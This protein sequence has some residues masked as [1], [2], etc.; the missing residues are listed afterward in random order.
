M[1]CAN[2]HLSQ[3]IKLERGCVYS[4]FFLFYRKGRQT[5][6][7]GRWHSA[8]IPGW[9]QTSC[10]YICIFNTWLPGCWDNL[11]LMWPSV[12]HI[13]QSIFLLKQGYKGPTCDI[14]I[15]QMVSCLGFPKIKQDAHPQHPFKPPVQAIFLTFKNSFKIS[16]LWRTSTSI[17]ID[18]R[19]AD[20]VQL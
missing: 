4:P 19:W 14:S 17:L 8:E 2:I 20:I 3:P 7:R 6:L 18:L 11:F 12:F 1:C 5:G 9:T 16:T 10:S 13:Y 15:H